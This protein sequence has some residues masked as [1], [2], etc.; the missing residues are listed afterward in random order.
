MADRCKAAFSIKLS[1]SESIIL[2]SPINTYIRC[3]N[4]KG[5]LG[6]KSNLSQPNYLMCHALP[7]KDS[8]TFYANKNHLALSSLSKNKWVSN[9]MSVVFTSK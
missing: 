5:S 7:F 2:P 8:F 3:F 1:Y 9:S 6:S 4:T